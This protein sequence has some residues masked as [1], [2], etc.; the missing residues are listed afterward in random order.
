MNAME[1]RGVSL[2]TLMALLAAG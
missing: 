1:K 2:L